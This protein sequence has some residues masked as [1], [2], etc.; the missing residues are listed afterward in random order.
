[1]DEEEERHLRALL[2]SLERVAALSEFTSGAKTPA[3]WNVQ[4]GSELAFDD[5]QTHPHRVSHAAWTAATVAVDHLMALRATLVREESA[6][7]ASAVLHT[8]AQ[9]SLVRGVIENASRAMWL[10]GPDERLVRVQRRL[11]L[12]VK[13]VKDS[14]KLHSRFKTQPARS[15]EARLAEV[16]RLALAA[17]APSDTLK[18]FL[19][20]PQYTKIVEEGGAYSKLGGQLILT[21]WS[22]CSSLAH[23]DINGT[24]GLLRHEIVSQDDET[25]LA[26]VTGNFSMLRYTT[27]AG[28][29]LIDQALA[30][31]TQR[32]VGP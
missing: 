11:A 32:T 25:A 27:Q 7:R 16:Q 26:R 14:T 5:A 6:E 15:E 13:E 23:G 2:V 10:L 24:F 18:R 20:A 17:G 8:H 29:H 28:I 3:P 4:P 12:Q 19:T 22:A 30:L 1:M 21:F 9:A 31:Y